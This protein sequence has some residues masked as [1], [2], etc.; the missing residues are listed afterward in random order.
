MVVSNHH[1]VYHSVLLTETTTRGVLWKKVFLNVL[2]N[3]QENTCTRVS[4]LIK[5]QAS[6]L[7]KKRFWHRLFCEFC[8]ISKNTFF[9][10]HVRETTSV[11]KSYCNIPHV[12]ISNK[13]PKTTLKKRFSIA[14]CIH[15]IFLTNLFY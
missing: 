10:E 6:G 9:T 8:E 13:L 5:L 14:N 15:A 12:T 3:S 7:L 4:F 1:I 11:L 2:Q